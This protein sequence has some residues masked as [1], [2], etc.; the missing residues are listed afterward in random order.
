MYLRGVDIRVGLFRNINSKS[1]Y[2]LN[3]LLSSFINS[4]IRKKIR[5]KIISKIKALMISQKKLNC[6]IMFKATPK[7]FTFLRGFFVVQ[8]FGRK[9]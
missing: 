4:N 1:F 6:I 7:N 5:Y 8:R 3:E 9:V 2:I